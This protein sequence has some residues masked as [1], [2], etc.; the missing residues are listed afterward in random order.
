[1]NFKYPQVSGYSANTP[2]M[3]PDQEWLKLLKSHIVG[4]NASAVD[5]VLMFMRRPD[6]FQLLTALVTD[7]TRSG[8]FSHESLPFGNNYNTQF[9]VSKMLVVGMLSTTHPPLQNHAF[10]KQPEN[11]YPFEFP[12]YQGSKTPGVNAFKPS[13]EVPSQELTPDEV[14]EQQQTLA[15]DT[16][17][18][19]MNSVRNLITGLND[20]VSD[21]EQILT[22]LTSPVKQ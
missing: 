4:N 5:M 6:S 14:R 17:Q 18:Q 10:G 21:M 1:M 15:I 19:E 7:L 2:V 8:L 3:F 22:R 20:R 16:L 9:V 11:L 13:G 12:Q